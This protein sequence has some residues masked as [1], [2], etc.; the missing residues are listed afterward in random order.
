VNDHVAGGLHATVRGATVVILVAIAAAS[1][2]AQAASPT[3]T[4]AQA[5]QYLQNGEA[6]KAL[7]LL[8]SLPQGGANIA[9]AQILACHV[10][11]AVQQWDAAVSECEQ[12]VRLDSQNSVYH[13]WLG[14]AVGLKAGHVSFLSA[15]SQGKRVLSEFEEAVK[16]NPH[17]PEALMDLGEFYKQAPGMVGGGLD[18]AENIA[19]Q[20]DKIDP[21][22][23][24]QLHGRVAEDRGDYSTAES[25]YKQAIAAAAHPALYWTTLASFYRARKRWTDMESAIQSCESAA[26]RDKHAAVALYDGAGV[27]IDGKRDPG[28]A[29]RLLEEY[30]ASPN[31]TEEGPAFEAHVRLAKMQKQLGDTSRA[32]QEIAAALALAHDYKPALEAKY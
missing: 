23:A 1:L 5:N 13:M 30:L 11:Y 4:I 18:K 2:F 16:L 15:Y 22:R 10:H 29:A 27:L 21:A 28:T 6:D 12:A 24:H 20:L 9:E 32:Q 31:K 14:R 19:A 26:Q 8:K 7:A 17:S 25:E 3:Q